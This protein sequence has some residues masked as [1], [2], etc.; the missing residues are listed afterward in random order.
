MWK[1][2]TYLDFKNI[3]LANVVILSLSGSHKNKSI[4]M[5]GSYFTLKIRNYILHKRCTGKINWYRIYIK[6]KFTPKLQRNDK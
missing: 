4:Y 1:K 3:V 5:S 2:D 6:K